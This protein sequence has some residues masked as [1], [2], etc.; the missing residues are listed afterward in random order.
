MSLDGDS[1]LIMVPEVLIAAL[2]TLSAAL[3]IHLQE[4]NASGMGS[5]CN[6]DRKSSSRLC[7]RSSSHHR[8]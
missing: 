5:T 4:Q 6:I 2:A 3:G 7:S 8:G 1:E